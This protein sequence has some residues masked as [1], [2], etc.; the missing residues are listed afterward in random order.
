MKKVILFSAVIAMVSAIGV[1]YVSTSSTRDMSEIELANVEALAGDENAG[2]SEISG[3]TITAMCDPISVV[4]IDYCAVYCPRCYTEWRPS[5][6]PTGKT[7]VSSIKGCCT[8]GY[9]F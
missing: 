6:S 8:C 4:V 9:C 3:S 5:G 7:D 2:G 1:N